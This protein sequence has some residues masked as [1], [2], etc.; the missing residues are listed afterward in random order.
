MSSSLDNSSLR[1]NILMI[2]ALVIFLLVPLALIILSYP[3][4]ISGTAE[5]VAVF[6]VVTS[7]MYIIGDS[8]W[9]FLQ[10]AQYSKNLADG[11]FIK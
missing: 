4:I 9:M 3:E 8:V 10:D 11:Q 5:Y 2:S 7:F 6:G 1:G